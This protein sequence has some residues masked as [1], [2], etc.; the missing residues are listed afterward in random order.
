[1]D[2]LKKT[3][4]VKGL[5]LEDIAVEIL[6]CGYHSVKEW[7]LKIFNK[8]MEFENVREDWV[9]ECIVPVYI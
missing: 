8:Y 2:A 5:R 3:K 4:G 7:L 9:L 6:K 1:M